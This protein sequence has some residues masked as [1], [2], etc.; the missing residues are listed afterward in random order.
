MISAPLRRS[1]IHEFH[2]KSQAK[3][4]DFGGWEMPIEYPQEGGG[5][6]LNEHTAVRERVG[7]F[8]VSHLGKAEVKGPGALSFLNGCITNDLEKISNGQAQYNLL[9]DEATGGVIDDLIVYRRSDEDFFLVPNAANTEEVVA[10]IKSVAPKEIS[11]E[12]HHYSYAV[13][14]LQGPLSKEVLRD[15]NVE[16]NLEY[17]SFTET[18]IA[19]KKVIICRTGYTGEMG[20]EILPQWKDAYPVWNA[21]LQS[22]VKFGGLAAG[23]A[24]RDTLRTEMGYPLH[25]HELSLDISPLQAGANWAIA[26]RKPKFLGKTALLKERE[27]GPKR[28]LRGL[29]LVERGVPRA[30]MSVL[31]DDNEVGKTTSGTFSPSLKQGI[32]LALLSKDIELEQEVSI[33]IRGKRARAKVVKPP[34]VPSRVR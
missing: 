7:L 2:E 33:D 10:R 16:I 30:G 25:G 8:D 21:L 12:N 32:A 11:I 28:I 6:V 27:S 1:P 14:A 17:M 26:W 31:N 4:A 34:F 3:L 23:L 19:D 9:C 29:A 22:V 18:E 20:F 24:A 5:G 15:L 13:F